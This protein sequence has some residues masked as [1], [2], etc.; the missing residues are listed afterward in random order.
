MGMFFK[1]SG[2]AENRI[3][4]SGRWPVRL[5]HFYLVDDYEFPATNFPEIFF[6]QEGNL[7]HETEVGTQAVREGSVMM[8]NPGVRHT[9]KQPEE[10]V[11]TRLRYLPEWLSQEYEII[12]NSP[13]LFSLFF[14]QSWFRYP[15]EE[16][17][18]VFSTRGEGNTRVRAE[19][20]FLWELLRNKR[21]LEPI[22]RV[23]VL[24]LMMLLTDE[25]QRFW[26][27]VSEIDIL[28]EVKH[29]LD[30]IE[31]TIR[32]A[33]PF[34]AAKIA[35]GGFEKRAIDE[36]FYETIGLSLEEYARR[37]RVFHAACRLLASDEE[38]RNI[39]KDLGYPAIADFRKEFES[40][41]DIQPAVYR[42]KFGTGPVKEIVE[43]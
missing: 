25:H 13:D 34:E 31:V 10:V 21:A 15:R 14:D 36:A 27:G 28:P 32:R 1:R 17:F 24:K 7:L 23:S 29:A 11:L 41:F 9:V 12:V 20:D 30:H 3:E 5:T 19:L 43:A 18:Q 2:I 42:E 26:R 37:R 38:P 39:S 35:R 33:A 22:T 8:V 6:V 4:N 40:V 16:H